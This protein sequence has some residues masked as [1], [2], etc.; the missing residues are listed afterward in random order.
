MFRPWKEFLTCLITPSGTPRGLEGS[1]NYIEADSSNTRDDLYVTGDASTM[2]MNLF[3]EVYNS[4]G[5]G[6]LSMEAMGDRAANRL[7]E[8]IA[9][10]PLFYYGPFTGLLVRNAAYL[11]AGRL[12]SNH[13]SEFPRGGHL[14][15]CHF[16]MNLPAE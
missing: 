10:N 15:E 2:N 7:A 11:F 14:G 16:I 13:S 12:L 8:S 4:I 5:D 6:A 1:H 3:M 9:T